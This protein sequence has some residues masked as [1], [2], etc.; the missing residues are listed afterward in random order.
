MNLNVFPKSYYSGVDQ[1]KEQ[2]AS[3]KIIYEMKRGVFNGPATIFINEKKVCRTS[4]SDQIEF[5]KSK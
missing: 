3:L 1:D 4:F 2:V 5:I